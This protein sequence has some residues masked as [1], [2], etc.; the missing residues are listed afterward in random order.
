M[1]ARREMRRNRRGH[2]TG[3][4][5]KGVVSE[6]ETGLTTTISSQSSALAKLNLKCHRNYSNYL[7]QKDLADIDNVMI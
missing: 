4:V 5:R 3:Q 2:V 1:A 7:Q 6:L